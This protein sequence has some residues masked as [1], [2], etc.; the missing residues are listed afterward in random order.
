MPYGTAMGRLRKLVLFDVLKRTNLNV[1]FQCGNTIEN[2]EELSLEHKEPWLHDSPEKFWDL[3]NIAFSHLRCNCKASRR[4]TLSPPTKEERINRVAFTPRFDAP[5]NKT[6]CSAC[7]QYLDLTK[8]SKNKSNAN[9]R[10]DEC[11]TC[12][13]IRRSPNKHKI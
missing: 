7:K 4:E 12:R 1:C 3:G 11:R 5:E 10:Q 13:S 9:G 2:A 8:F 6:W